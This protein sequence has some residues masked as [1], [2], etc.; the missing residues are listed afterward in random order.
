MV[1]APT[2][3]LGKFSKGSRKMKERKGCI[4]RQG[5]IIKFGRVPIMI[6]ESSLD[7]A[8]WNSLQKQSFNFVMDVESQPQLPINTENS[9]NEAIHNLAGGDSSNNLYDNL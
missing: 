2:C 9:R 3:E 4:I 1:V 6:K 5:D 7:L 8:K